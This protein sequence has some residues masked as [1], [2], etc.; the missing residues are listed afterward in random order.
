[1]EVK[2]KAI[3]KSKEE[4]FR[5]A[6]MCMV[7]DDILKLRIVGVT[8]IVLLVCLFLY[9]Y[10]NFKRIYSHSEYPFIYGEIFFGICEICIWIFIC[11]YPA[12][13]LN[14]S[15][16]V[17]EKYKNDNCIELSVYFYETCIKEESILGNKSL[18]YSNI[19]KVYETD[20]KFIFRFKDKG[21]TFVSKDSFVIGDSN[22]FREFL[23][24]KIDNK[25]TKYIIK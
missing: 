18:E 3:T 23:K 11:K 19:K 1:M 8:G 12:V 4:D 9:R 16:K 2:F 6:H 20:T 5:E 15:I 22:S 24:S 13:I 7:K 17:R 25:A 21:Y 14:R 10:I